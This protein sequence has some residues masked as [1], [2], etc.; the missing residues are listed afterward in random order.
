MEFTSIFKQLKRS[1][2]KQFGNSVSY[3]RLKADLLA[4]P[5][6]AP[7]HTGEVY[8]QTLLVL[9]AWFL[10]QTELSDLRDWKLLRK[11]FFKHHG[12]ELMKLLDDQYVN[13]MQLQRIPVN[14]YLGLIDLFLEFRRSDALPAVSY[15][16]LARI[17]VH[18]FDVPYTVEGV[19]NTL[20][21][22]NTP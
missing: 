21:D 16:Q 10:M 1:L 11:L 22:R 6:D 17:I 4:F 2:H 18:C 15:M 19:K 8:D 14:D 9:M 5:T 13:S 7:K 12:L 20:C 3:M